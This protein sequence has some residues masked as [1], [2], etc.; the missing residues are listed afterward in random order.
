[1]A[2]IEVVILPVAYGADR[3]GPESL[4]KNAQ[5]MIKDLRGDTGR[6]QSESSIHELSLVLSWIDPNLS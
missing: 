3:E 6:Y 1:M 2:N 4:V 5:L